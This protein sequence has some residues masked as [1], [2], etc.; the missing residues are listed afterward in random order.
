MEYD[1]FGSSQ[2]LMPAKGY[3]LEISPSG[4]QYALE[5][6][7]KSYS[8]NGNPLE[9]VSKNDFYTAYIW[10]YG[11]RYM[12]AQVNNAAVAQVAYSSLRTMTKVI[13]PSPVR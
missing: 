5:S 4:S 11:D 6:E 3:K 1:Q 7:V 8:A 13:D 9:V 12:I 10:G 2:I